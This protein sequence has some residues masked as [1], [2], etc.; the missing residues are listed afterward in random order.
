MQRSG[1]VTVAGVSTADVIC[2]LGTGKPAADSIARSAQDATG[3][4]GPLLIDVLVVAKPAHSSWEWQLI[5]Y[6]SIVTLP[7]SK[8]LLA[9]P[10]IEETS[11]DRG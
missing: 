5:R 2:V 3:A 9:R 7:K 1:N 11:H 6:P 8:A 4:I 10:L